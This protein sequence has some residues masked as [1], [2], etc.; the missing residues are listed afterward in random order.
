MVEWKDGMMVARKEMQM[1]VQMVYYLVQ[2]MV[3]MRVALSGDL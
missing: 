3:E 2:K 1:V